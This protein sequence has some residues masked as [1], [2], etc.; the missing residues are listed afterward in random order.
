M[1][2]KHTKRCS[3]SL[4]IKKEKSKLRSPWNTILCLFEIK[5][6][7]K[8]TCQYQV[9]KSI[10]IHRIFNCWWECCYNQL[11]KKLALSPKCKYLYWGWLSNTTPRLLL[12]INLHIFITRH[13]Q[14]YSQ[15]HSL[16]KEKWNKMKNCSI[17]M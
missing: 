8:S 6:K 1:V 15:Q 3:K 16:Q 9:L 4:V 13:V 12:K 11:E 14:K 2:S 5:I 17:S 10:E 7:K